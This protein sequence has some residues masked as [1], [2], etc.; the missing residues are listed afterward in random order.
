MIRFSLCCAQDHSFEGWF[1]S[2]D[3]FDTQSK[4]RL[5]ECPMCGSS[6]VAKALMAPAVSTSRSQ[7]QRTSGS[8]VV[9]Q[10]DDNEVVTLSHG[11]NQQEIMAQMRILAKKLK[12]GAEYVGDKFAAEARK[13]HDGE[14]DARGIYGE[15]TIA[16]AQSL[17]EDGIDFLPIP[18]FPE[19]H[20]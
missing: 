3:D 10:V 11:Q 9:G 17:A 16:E 18:S 4:K 6:S 1:R 20:N 7:E 13:I 15:A 8:R 2:N 14:A 12:D 19:D 5:I